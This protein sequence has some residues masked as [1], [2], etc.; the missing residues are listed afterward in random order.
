[1]RRS[2]Q[3]AAQWLIEGLSEAIDVIIARFDR[4]PSYRIDIAAGGIVIDDCGLP[5]G[6]LSGPETSR[7]LEPPELAA[8]LSRAM[9]GIT[10]PA[11]WVWRRSL[12]PIG[13]DGAAY[14]DAFV[15]HHIERISPWR[16][17][18]VYHQ[19]ET[20]PVENDPARLTIDVSI[21]P[22]QL[23]DPVAG[24]VK[25]ISPRVTLFAS[26]AEGN[27]ILSLPIGAGHDARHRKTRRVVLATL[28]LLSVML[29]GWLACTAWNGAEIDAQLAD[30]DSTIATHRRTIANSSTEAP[31]DPARALWVRRMSQPYAVELLDTLSQTL[32]DSAYLIDVRLEKDV[33]L[34]SG[35]TNR[36]SDLVPALEGSG[37]FA[38]VQFAA[39]TTR[40][41]GGRLDRFQIEMRDGAKGHGAREKGRAP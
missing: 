7:R 36:P 31:Q 38:D 16:S 18:D 25:Q 32:P 3:T 23:V 41:E 12:P 2:I 33:I 13:V 28:I 19:V 27:D 6:R 8:R 35:I 4:R 21:V 37:R 40:M 11:S 14:L 17:A 10:L 1:M 15:G 30:I 9:I 20:R 5:V 22:K 24:V 34:I 39:A 29:A 26:G